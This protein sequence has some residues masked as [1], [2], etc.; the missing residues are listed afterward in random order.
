M[1]IRKL[2]ERFD[3]GT[4]VHICEYVFTGAGEFVD[5]TTKC[6]YAGSAGDIPIW[7]SDYEIDEIGLEVHATEQEAEKKIVR[8]VE[9]RIELRVSKP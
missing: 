9:G 6:L 2:Y 4:P 1:K 7:L 8:G 5:V 3:H